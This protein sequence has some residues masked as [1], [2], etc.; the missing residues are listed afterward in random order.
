MSERKLESTNVLNEVFLEERC[1]LNKV[2]KLVGQR[3]ASEILLLIEKDYTRFSQL[4]TQ[5]EGVSDM[6]LS[7]SLNELIAAEILTKAIYSEIPVRVEYKLTES[8][9]ELVELLHNLC[10]WGKRNV[11]TGLD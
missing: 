9:W 3:W 2:L 5:L 8:G 1:V 11:E 10:Q 6:A 4:K 7:R